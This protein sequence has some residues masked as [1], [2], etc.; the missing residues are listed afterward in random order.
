VPWLLDGNNVARGGDRAGVRRAALGL[1]RHER[2]R[3]VVF[4]DGA[5]PPGGH[6]TETLGQVEVRYAAH[7]DTAIVAFLK[8][9]GTGWK[10]ATD[11]RALT[12]AVRSL[13][14]EAVPAAVFRQKAEAAQGG[15]S[16]R[17]ARQANLGAEMAYLSDP[18][19]RLAEQPVRVR[20][21]KANSKRRKR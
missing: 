6:E 17:D 3:I 16:R 19:N 14:A 8:H 2:V 11:D 9:A 18:G 20:L 21:R 13:G 4:F 5:P 15:P 10:V 12:A 1:A 7:A